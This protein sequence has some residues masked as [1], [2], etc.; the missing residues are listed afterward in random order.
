MKKKKK[1]HPLRY[2]TR[3]PNSGNAETGSDRRRGIVW[4]RLSQGHVIDHHYLCSIVD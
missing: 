4:S 2:S 1:K 3:M